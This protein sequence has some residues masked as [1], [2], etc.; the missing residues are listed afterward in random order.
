MAAVAV[1][2]ALN[3]KNPMCLGAHS[4]WSLKWDNALIIILGGGTTNP[5]PLKIVFIKNPLD[6]N[7]KF[8]DSI[9]D[10]KIL[11]F[12][13]FYNFASPKLWQSRK[14]VPHEPL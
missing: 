2:V 4:N 3:A 12:C 7:L 9:C 10:P 11:K 14:C 1:A 13:L 5:R 8:F 6:I